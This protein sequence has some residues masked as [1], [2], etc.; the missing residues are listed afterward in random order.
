MQNSPADAR[1]TEQIDAHGLKALRLRACGSEAVVYLQGAHVASFSTSEHGE[2]LWLSDQAV[3]AGGKAIRGGVPICF[4][5]FGA[6][7]SRSELPAHG[8]A[9]TTEFR[10]EG[11]EMHGDYVMARLLLESGPATEPLFPHG[12]TA[13]LS[14]TVGRELSLSFEVENTG[15]D[16]FDY[17]LALHSYLGVSDVRSVELAGLSGASYDDKVTGARACLEQAASLRFSGETDR[18]Y[19]STARITV[20]DSARKRRLIID[21]T[22]SSSTVV[23]NPWI[24]KA[25]RM[26]DF[27]DDEWPQMLCVEAANVRPHAVHLTPGA[28]HATTTIIS[29][30]T[31]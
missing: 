6:H 4:P 5:W 17:E 7:P 27:G 22:R 16:A 1:H 19:D 25:K 20:L 29:A 8:F 30:E 26:S 10:F 9:R 12:F 28:R 13:R 11:A 23:W 21:K 18:V 24:E 14:V 2:L 31:L 3:Y 15:S